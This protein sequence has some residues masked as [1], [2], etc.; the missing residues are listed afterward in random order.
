MYVK[1]KG[2]YDEQCQSRRIITLNVIFIFVRRCVGKFVGS[3]VGTIWSVPV[4]Q[5][6]EVDSSLPAFVEHFM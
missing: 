1:Y 5:S 3:T 4:S 2:S 6:K